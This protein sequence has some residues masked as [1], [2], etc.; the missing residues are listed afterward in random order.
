MKFPI[1]LPGWSIALPGV[2]VERVFM[3]YYK[4]H[5]CGMCDV[6]HISHCTPVHV[7]VHSNQVDELSHIQ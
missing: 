3:E 7:H 4:I 2:D 5:T 6:S 1:R